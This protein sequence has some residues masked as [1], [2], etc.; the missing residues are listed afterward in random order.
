MLH[1]N[2]ALLSPCV[3]A[4]QDSVLPQDWPAVLARRAR[5]RA[6]PR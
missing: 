3:R 2:K 5:K 4:R 6:M 1:I